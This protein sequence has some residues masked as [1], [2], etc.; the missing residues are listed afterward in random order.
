PVLGYFARMCREKGLDTLVDAYVLLKKR[1][2]TRHLRLHVGGG[3][4]P[5]DESFVEH[6]RRKLAEA[7]VLA[8]TQFF[9]N[10]DHAAKLA[11]YRGLSI[12]STPAL[13]GEAFG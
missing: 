13:Y 5:G 2:R 1:A 9:P 3:C 4:G 12:F 7:G 8:D 11:F 6:Q 10:V